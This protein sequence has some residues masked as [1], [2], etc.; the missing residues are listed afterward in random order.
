MLDGISVFLMGV[1]IAAAGWFTVA[2]SL[3]VLSKDVPLDAALFGVIGLEAGAV[4]SAYLLAWAFRRRLY[5]FLVYVLT[6]ALLLTFS[7]TGTRLS[8]SVSMQ[9]QQSERGSSTDLLVETLQE[10]RNGKPADTISFFLSAGA[11]TLPL[12]GFL[13]TRPERRSLSEKFV[14]AR[15]W[16]KELSSQIQCSEGLVFWA[17]RTA[18]T[19]LFNRRQA[20]GRLADFQRQVHRLRDNVASSLTT[21]HVPDFIH[22]ALSIRLGDMCGNAET[23]AFA[24]QG[25]LDQAG[26]SALNDCLDAVQLSQLPEQKKEEVKQLLIRH[27]QQFNGLS[28]GFTHAYAPNRSFAGKEI[29]TN[30]RPKKT[31]STQT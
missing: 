4:A 19:L 28:R 23:T 15:V 25:K 18:K 5:W 14:C 16:M 3:R 12:L 21:L 22:E 13:G 10:L 11:V 26:L 1:C 20:D 31:I 24:A 9:Q 6:S 29:S 30:V 27:F 7:Y 8:F 17:A 2:T